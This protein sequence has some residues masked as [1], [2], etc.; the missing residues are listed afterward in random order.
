MYL[1]RIES[2]SPPP[3][4]RT[5]RTLVLTWMRSHDDV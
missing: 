3:R 1:Q 4:T 2:D 5:L